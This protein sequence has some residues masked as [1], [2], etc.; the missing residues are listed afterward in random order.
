M[1]SPDIHAF[2]RALGSLEASVKNVTETVAN[3]TKAWAEQERNAS[4]GRRVLHD[5]LDDVRGDV[6]ALDRTVADLAKEMTEIS[7]AVKEFKRQRERAIG[8]RSFGRWIWGLMLT[9][10]G[11]IGWAVNEWLHIPR[12]H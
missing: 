5:K 11:G 7:P 12:P 1:N 4:E 8:A 10:A 2:S 9:A 3:M 6:V